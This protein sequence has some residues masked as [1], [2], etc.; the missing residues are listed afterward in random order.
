MYTL[1]HDNS[2]MHPKANGLSVE[3]N[4]DYRKLHT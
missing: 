3:K 1:F 4:N 2:E